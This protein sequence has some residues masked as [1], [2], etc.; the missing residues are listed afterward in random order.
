MTKFQQFLM[1]HVVFLR[2]KNL[3]KLWFSNPKQYT[4]VRKLGRHNQMNTKTTN[5]DS[6]FFSVMQTQKKYRSAFK[7]KSLRN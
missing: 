1:S 7:K 5:L 6:R 4:M 2:R 3:Y